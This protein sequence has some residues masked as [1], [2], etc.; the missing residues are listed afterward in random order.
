[1]KK[2]S[3]VKTCKL[4]G[5]LWA[6]GGQNSNQNGDRCPNHWRPRPFFIYLFFNLLINEHKHSHANTYS[7][8]K[9]NIIF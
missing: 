5:N 7:N 4:T 8:T 3:S 9:K 6:T 2:Q 1:M